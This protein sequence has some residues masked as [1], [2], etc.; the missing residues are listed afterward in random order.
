MTDW[1][2]KYVQE[3]FTPIEHSEDLKCNFCSKIV[4]NEDFRW[5]R[6]HL[7]NHHLE[8]YKKTIHL[9]NF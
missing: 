1:D 4:T 5:M 9:F 3:C 2:D 8:Q 7:G 6:I